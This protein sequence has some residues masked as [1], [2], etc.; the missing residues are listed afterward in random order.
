MNAKSKFIISLAVFAF[1]V[2]LLIGVITDCNYTEQDI[3][4]A[5]E[6]AE[7][8]SSDFTKAES[9]KEVEKVYSKF[10]VLHEKLFKMVN[11]RIS[12]AHEVRYVYDEA[13]NIIFSEV[14]AS[15]TYRN[16]VV[17]SISIVSIIISFVLT[18]VY[19]ELIIKGRRNSLT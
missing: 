5:C 6:I 17:R 3:R 16:I 9:H 14:L 15:I 2:G 1:S 7:E 18:I 8:I 11:I 4:H 12:G 13:D 19:A 10:D